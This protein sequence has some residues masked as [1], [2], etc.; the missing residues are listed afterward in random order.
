[1]NKT[2]LE[3]SNSVSSVPPCFIHCMF[4][5]SE[6]P[7]S[8]MFQTRFALNSLAEKTSFHELALQRAAEKSEPE[9]R[10]LQTTPADQNPWNRCYTARD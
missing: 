3:A 2:M 1:M 6:M 8:L 10:G 7:P 9:L 5:S 4:C